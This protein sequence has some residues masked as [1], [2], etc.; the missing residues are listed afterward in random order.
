MRRTLSGILV[1]FVLLTACA[2]PPSPASNPPTPS[3]AT[4]TPAPVKTIGE[5]KRRE[6][7]HFADITKGLFQMSGAAQDYDLPNV[8]VGCIS[9]RTASDNLERDLPSPD[10]AVNTALRAMIDSYRSAASIAMTITDGNS[11]DGASRH[12]N[13]GSSHMYDAFNLLGLNM[14]PAP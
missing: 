8:R 3:D 2:S 6:A 7:D 4:Y 9:L 10:E 11:L 13:E 5:W 1:V 14:T 12:L